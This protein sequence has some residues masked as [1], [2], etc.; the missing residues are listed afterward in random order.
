MNTTCID[1]QSKSPNLIAVDFDPFADSEFRSSKIPA[2]LMTGS[3]VSKA[4]AD[5]ESKN[6]STLSVNNDLRSN[7]KLIDF[8]PF[9]DGEILL[10]APAT[11]SQKEIWL[12]IQMSDQANLAISNPS[13]IIKN[14]L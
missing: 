14:D 11:E 2:E 3:S 1:P 10:T 13:R 8:D 9:A 12:A 7:L 4:S 6:Q 5:I